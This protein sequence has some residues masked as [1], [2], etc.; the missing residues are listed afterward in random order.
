MKKIK[1]QKEEAQK[2]QQEIFGNTGGFQNNHND[3][4]NQE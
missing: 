2:R 3:E 4:G 1:Q